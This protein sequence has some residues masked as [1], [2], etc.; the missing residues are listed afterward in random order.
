MSA[1][2]DFH[3]VPLPPSSAVALLDQARR[4]LREADRETAPASRFAAAYLGALRA[5]AAVLAARGR[6]HRGRAKPT[7]VWVLLPRLAPE[8]T[9]WAAFFDACSATRELVLAG[10]TGHVADREADDLV[11]Q[12]GQFAVLVGGIVHE[13]G[14]GA[15]FAVST[16]EAVPGGGVPGRVAVPTGEVVYEGGT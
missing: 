3:R 11:R 8:F 10:V 13:G 15:G 2:T 4:C 12:V 5:A 1:A 14:V 6:P 7:S 9:E 16:C